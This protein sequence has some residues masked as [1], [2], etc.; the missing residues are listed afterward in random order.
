MFNYKNIFGLF[1]D[2]CGLNKLTV[3]K[4]IHFI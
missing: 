2:M 3:I 4:A 1:P